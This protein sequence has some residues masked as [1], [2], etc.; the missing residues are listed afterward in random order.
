MNEIIACF[1]DTKPPADLET[2]FFDF[3]TEM[4]NNM[5]RD[6][7]CMSEESERRKSHIDDNLYLFQDI[8]VSLTLVPQKVDR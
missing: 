6:M 8:L 2:I 4:E 5:C 3:E 7:I 1:L